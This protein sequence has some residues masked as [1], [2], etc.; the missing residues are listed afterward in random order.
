M[1]LSPALLVATAAFL[2]S[3]SARAALQAQVYGH[4]GPPSAD[5]FGNSVSGAGD[6]D[7][8]GVP[9]LLIGA[10][11]S[12]AGAPVGGQAHAYSGRTGALLHT[13]T[14]TTAGDT[15]GWAVAP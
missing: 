10:T 7:A 8:D 13:W 11:Y 12:D 1:K 2:L 5:H 15:L 14:G 6:L 9:D 3:S 4:F